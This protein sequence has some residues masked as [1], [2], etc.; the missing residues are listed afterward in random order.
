MKNS[1]ILKYEINP[2]EYGNYPLNWG[3]IF[4]RE[5]PIAVEVGCGNGE[6]LVNWARSRP[7][8]NF[9]GIELSLASGERIQSRIHS[10]RLENIRILRDDARFALPELFADQS[11]AQLVMNFPDPWP[12][13]KHRERRLIIPSFIDSLGGV[14]TI[15][16][17]FELYT[18]QDWYA[19]KARELFASSSLFAAGEVEIN[20]PRN[21]STKYERKW[22]EQYRQVY[23]FQAIKH[24]NGQI[25]RLLEN[26]TMPH[27]L[28]QHEVSMTEIKK[29]KN[30]EQVWEDRVYKIKEVFSSPDEQAY[31]LRTVTSDRN[32]VQNFFILVARHE[33]GYIVKIDSGYQPYRTPAVKMALQE[34]GRRLQKPV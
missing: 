22:R 18:D 11:I 7:D 31:L 4:G 9:L 25:N 21:V 10:G 20:P 23:R 19:L 26:I 15:G 2:R 3:E 12:K 6:F 13:E 5:G 29:L 27:V 14:L 24:Q 8:W 28:I 33:Q 17:I 34:V 32:Y 16:G 30:A 1:D